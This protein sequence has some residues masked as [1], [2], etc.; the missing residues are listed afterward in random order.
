MARDRIKSRASFKSE[1]WTLK[2]ESAGLTG[3]KA[4][5]PCLLSVDFKSSDWESGG[6]SGLSMIGRTWSNPRFAVDTV[7][8]GSS[9]ER[10]VAESPVSSRHPSSDLVVCSVFKARAV[11]GAANPSK[12]KSPRI[13]AT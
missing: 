10:F 13:T 6:E 3:V 2:R 7:A 8:F 1:V 9:I 4:S 11:I 5:W 12:I